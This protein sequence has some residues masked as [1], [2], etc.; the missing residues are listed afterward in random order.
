MLLGGGVLFGGD[1]G[2]LDAVVTPEGAAL[3]D[4]GFVNQGCMVVYG[5]VARNC[6]GRGLGG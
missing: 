2:G 4:T 1:A 3:Q 5:G 6:T